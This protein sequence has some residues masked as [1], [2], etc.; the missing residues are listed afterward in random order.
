M[1]FVW[2]KKLR[3]GQAS[4]KLNVIFLL[5]Y[6]N[7]ELWGKTDGT[8]GCQK[9]ARQEFKL[10]SNW[11]NDLINN[12]CPVKLEYLFD[13]DFEAWLLGETLNKNIGWYYRL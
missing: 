8:N 13:M 3:K 7:Q 4:D 5:S 11:E 12:Q 10:K 1:K 2:E 9:A 6:L